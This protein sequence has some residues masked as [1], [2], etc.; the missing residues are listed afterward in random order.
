MT[1]VSAEQA[2]GVFDHGWLAAVLPADARRFRVADPSLAAVL[3]DAGAELSDVRPDVDIAPAAEL[4]GQAPLAVVSF[5]APPHD[6]SSLLARVARRVVSSAR[7]R[8]KALRARSIVRSK[9]YGRPEVVLWDVRQQFRLP[10]RALAARSAVELLPQRALVLGRRTARTPT[11]LDAALEAVGASLEGAPSIRAGLVTAMTDR[12]L[13]RVAIGP[14]RRQVETQSRALDT[15]RGAN[16]STTVADRVP[17]V[18][19]S[20]KAGLAD[21]SLERRL[22]GRRPRGALTD[23]LRGQCVDF[24]VE[25]HG[26]SGTAVPASSASDARMIAEVRPGAEEELVALGGRLDETLAGLPRGFGHGDFFLGNLLVDGDRLTGVV[27]WDSGGPGR[28][29]LLDLFH[30]LHLAQ[31]PL[32]DEDWGQSLV[33]HLFPSARAGGGAT[34]REYCTRVGVEPDGRLLEALAVAYW[35]DRAAYILQTHRQRRTEARWLAR[36][37]DEVLRSFR[38]N[39]L[40]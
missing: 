28:L 19:A 15:L 10:G 34:V 26:V 1:S 27:D 25:L 32:G 13:L 7:V 16:L 22:P 20:G 17:W 14:A 3:T 12:G 21:W 2:G 4:R 40:A 29:P 6:S 31:Y 30:L 37:V 33:R 18:T 8:A 9:G 35:L 23:D 38:S 24:L 5:A 11:V 36:N 39:D